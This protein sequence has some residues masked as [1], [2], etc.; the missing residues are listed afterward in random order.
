MGVNAFAGW[1]FVRE[2][3]SIVTVKAKHAIAPILVQCHLEVL[4]MGWELRSI[5][6]LCCVRLFRCLF[7]SVMSFVTDNVLL[8]QFVLML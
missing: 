4:K 8:G 2:M 1:V 5:R 3:M 7:N 6:L